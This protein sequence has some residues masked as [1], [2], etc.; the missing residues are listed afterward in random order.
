MAHVNKKPVPNMVGMR[1]KAEQALVMKDMGNGHMRPYI[2]GTCVTVVSGATTAVV[3]SGTI[4]GMNV[5][6]GVY[7]P[8]TINSSTTCYITKDANEHSVLVTMASAPSAATDIDVMVFMSTA[9]TV[10]VS[11]YVGKRGYLTL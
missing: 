1:A 2:W 7:S 8:C 4:G 10:D 11:D 5:E 9:V 3:A 6:D